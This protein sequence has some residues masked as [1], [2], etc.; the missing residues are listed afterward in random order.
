MNMYIFHNN[1]ALNQDFEAKEQDVFV[2]AGGRFKIQVKPE[3]DFY[4]TASP[5][6]FC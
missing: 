1:I 2:G 5:S 3:P 6:I 4:K